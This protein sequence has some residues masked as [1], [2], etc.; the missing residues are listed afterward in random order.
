MER[1][2]CILYQ[3]AL[4]ERD[5]VLRDIEESKE[6]AD[7]PYIV[8]FVTQ[9]KLNSIIPCEETLLRELFS[10]ACLRHDILHE[11]ADGIWLEVLE[12]TIQA[13]NYHLSEYLRS[14]LVRVSN[15]PMTNATVE[16]HFMDLY[17]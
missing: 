13:R 6:S 9:R 1:V 12:V 17:P 7:N 10:K 16:P 5:K 15:V 14:K 8:S 11:D 2:A 3:R 4:C